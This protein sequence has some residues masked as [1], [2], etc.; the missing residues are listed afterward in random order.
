MRIASVIPSKGLFLSLTL[1]YHRWLLIGMEV[2]GIDTRKCKAHSAC[3]ASSSSLKRSGMSVKLILQK[4]N[5]SGKS[6][7]FK[8]LY[9]RAQSLRYTL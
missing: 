8:R 1:P 6:S 9:D 4:A 7:T 2:A 3:A 5:W